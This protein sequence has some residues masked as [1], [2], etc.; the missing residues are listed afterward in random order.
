V[1]VIMCGWGQEYVCVLMCGLDVG[2]ICG[3]GDGT[4]C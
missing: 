3:K 2:C 1:H 4:E